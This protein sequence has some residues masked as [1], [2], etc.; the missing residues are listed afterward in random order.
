MIRLP[1]PPHPWP[2]VILAVLFL[3]P[4]CSSSENRSWPVVEDAVAVMLT[5]LP[6]A[7]DA[8][9]RTPFIW[10]V[11]E[12]GKRDGD[13]IPGELLQKI[14]D[15]TGIRVHT[16][17]L[18]LPRDSTVVLT[19]FEP[20]IFPPDTTALLATW[21]FLGKE[22]G[23]FGREYIFRFKCSWV[24]CKRLDYHLTAILN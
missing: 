16:E 7:P 18:Q 15:R 2:G 4:G 3:L 14:T 23:W 17:D 5:E 6:K 9:G 13:S 22:G 20:R 10:G 12:T 21:V 1:E 11:W 8:P 24:G 19:I